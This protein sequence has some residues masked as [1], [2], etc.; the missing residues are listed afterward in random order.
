[1]FG[2]E[3]FKQL[4]PNRII[5][6][7]MNFKDGVELPKP[8]RAYPLSPAED[9]AMKEYIQ[10]ELESEKMSPSKSPSAAPCFFIKKSDGSLRMVV[11]YHTLNDITIKDSF[12]LPLI[13]NLIEA[14]KGSKVFFKLDL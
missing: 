8:A 10:A 7:K 9:K 13:T 12:P 14:T 1:M 5:D 11:D 6:C 3:L 2:K 4:P